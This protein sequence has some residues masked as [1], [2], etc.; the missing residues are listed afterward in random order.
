MAVVGADHQTVFA[1]FAHHVGNVIAIFADHVHAKGAKWIL[2]P[3]P[4]EGFEPMPRFVHHPGKPLRTGFN[5]AKTKPGEDLMD[6][7]HDNVVE[8]ANGG[9]P[10]T[11]KGRCNTDWMTIQIVEP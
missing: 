8:G 11:M 3:S 2:G 6:L 1:G 10:E 9:N 5:E 4:A 7:A